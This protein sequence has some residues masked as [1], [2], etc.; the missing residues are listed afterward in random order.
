MDPL[1]VYCYH[2]WYHDASTIIHLH[3][4]CLHVHALYI[5]SYV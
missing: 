3:V 4:L 1:H 5:M 2:L